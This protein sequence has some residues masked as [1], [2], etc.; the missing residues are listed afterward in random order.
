MRKLK[1]YR[2]ECLINGKPVW[3]TVHAVGRNQAVDRLIWLGVV[4]RT[5]TRA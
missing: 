2:A 5:I 4:V 3:V 1:K